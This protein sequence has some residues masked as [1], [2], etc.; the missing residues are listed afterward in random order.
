MSC[1]LYTIQ[2]P[3][4]GVSISKLQPALHHLP[5]D[6]HLNPIC[7]LQFSLQL[8][9][10]S[11]SAPE[12]YRTHA[13]VPWQ[14][15]LIHKSIKHQITLVYTNFPSICTQMTVPRQTHQWYYYNSQIIPLLLVW[16][17][18]GVKIG[19]KICWISSVRLF[20]LFYVCPSLY[21]GLA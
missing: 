5:K 21:G 6:I 13:T 19:H 18:M 4:K 1:S 7:G 8:H 10:F 17:K 2:T 11:K 9:H 20:S 16:T 12:A 14:C 3:C 15:L